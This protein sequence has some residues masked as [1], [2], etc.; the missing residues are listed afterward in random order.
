MERA[1]IAG[2]DTVVVACL[3]LSAI[4]VHAST[5]LKIVALL[6][7]WLK[8]SSGSGF[9]DAPFNPGIHNRSSLVDLYGL[10]CMPFSIGSGIYQDGTRKRCQ[11]VASQ[12][13]S[14]AL[15]ASP[16]EV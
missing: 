10:T 7:A 16:F 12:G 14:D 11:T 8:R 5:R 9:S 15:L 3:D 4:L 2:A 6:A 13:F 1:E